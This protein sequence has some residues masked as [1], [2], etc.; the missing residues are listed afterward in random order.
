MV[1][2]GWAETEGLQ[3]FSAVSPVPAFLAVFSESHFSLHIPS[4][5]QVSSWSLLTWQL[6]LYRVEPSKAF[7]S[8]SPLL[9]ARTPQHFL[10]RIPDVGI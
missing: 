2:S 10:V 4:P 1:E 5:A 6:R 9:T 3:G 7:L 8:S